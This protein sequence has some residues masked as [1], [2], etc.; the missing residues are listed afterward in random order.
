MDY[1][2]NYPMEYANTPSKNNM[3]WLYIGLGILAVIV[4][5]IIIFFILRKNKNNYCPGPLEYVDTKTKDDGSKQL[6][7]K[8]PDDIYKET[9]G[10][11]LSSGSGDL[12]GLAKNKQGTCFNQ[13]DAIKHW[14]NLVPDIPSDYY[15]K[16][17]DGK[18][19]QVY[20]GTQGQYYNSNC[21]K[22]DQD[23]SLANCYNV[24]FP[25]VLAED[26]KG[27]GVTNTNRTGQCNPNAD[28]GD[29]V[30]FNIN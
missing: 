24:H 13:E 15:S 11:F 17:S 14:R 21:S 16:R 9:G 1:S 28:L 30:H 10:I 22:S 29:K 2:S 27:L 3:K 4:I 18:Y 25:M 19:N 6:I 20:K 7:C 5:A 8:I 23:S 12:T 26:L